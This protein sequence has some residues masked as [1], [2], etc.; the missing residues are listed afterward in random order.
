M[1]FLGI[2]GVFP[3][4]D[5]VEELVNHL[6][7]GDQI[8]EPMPREWEEAL[9]DVPRLMGVV[10]NKTKFDAGFFGN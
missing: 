6:Y 5:N 9:P 8:T 1:S 2:A 7:N 4:S 3:A 10:K